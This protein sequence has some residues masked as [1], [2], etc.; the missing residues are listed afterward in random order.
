MILNYD[1]GYPRVLDHA[2]ALLIYDKTKH[3]KGIKETRS[4]QN[5][6][7]RRICHNI[8]PHPP[9][10]LKKHLS[11]NYQILAYQKA[12]KKSKRNEKGKIWED[13]RKSSNRASSYEQAQEKKRRLNSNN[14]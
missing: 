6:P 1:A 4:S 5:N 12:L 10:S 13:K 8:L 3:E 7:S 9:N 11:S 14:T 2:C